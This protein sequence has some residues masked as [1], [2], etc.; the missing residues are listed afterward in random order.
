[1]AAAPVFVPLQAR[2]QRSARIRRVGVLMV[3]AE[4]S[5]STRVALAKFRDALR[6]VGWSEGRNL[7]VNVRYVGA[8]DEIDSQVAEILRGA[9]EVIVCNS[10][11][12]TRAVHQQTRTVPIVF[13]GVGDPVA[14]GLLGSLA[15]PEGNA[16]GVTNV[17]YSIAGKWLEMLKEAAPRVI[18][19]AIV[20]NP[21]F[22]LTEGWFDAID[23][24]APLLGLNVIRT[25]FR[26][27]ADLEPAIDAFAA[28]PDGGVAVIPPG[29]V[30]DERATMFALA[31]RH[32][33]P[34]IY[35]SGSYASE[36]GLMGYGVET[37]EY[38][39]SAASYVD[40]LLR[41]AK[42]GDLPVQSPS[43]FEFVVNLKTAKAIGLDI[44]ATLV[45]RADTVI[46]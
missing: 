31:L 8:G 30:A 21:D 12:I 29:L 15:R 5:E 41:G 19:V 38:F 33:L 14:S 45:A 24:A 9:A 35:H 22:S 18:R 36:G 4:S 44:P 27:A 6:E 7:Q 28:T 39:R 17:Y 1:M 34:A 40:R 10:L 16:T 3:G 11:A 43:R 23:A 46:E 32:R 25:P 26:N 2:A 42:P 13:A 20:F 37:A